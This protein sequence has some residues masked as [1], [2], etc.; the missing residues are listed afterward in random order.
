MRRVPYRVNPKSD[1]SRHT[2]ITMRKIREGET[3][4]QDQEMMEDITAVVESEKEI[5]GHQSTG[6]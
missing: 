2:V 6:L 1:T 5:A 4:E 3:T